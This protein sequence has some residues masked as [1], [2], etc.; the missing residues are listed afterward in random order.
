MQDVFFDDKN[1]IIA[2][3]NGRVYDL[4][5]NAVI[6]NEYVTGWAKRGPSGVI[7]TNKP[8]A[9][10][11]V[12]LLLDDLKNKLAEKLSKNQEYRIH[13]WLKSKNL[14]FV[15]FNQWKILDAHETELGESKE[16][17]REKVTSIAEML[18][19]IKNNN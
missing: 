15:P 17:P 5:N 14:Q 18:K 16:K 10:E 4:T 9:I 12:N 13:S 19:I 3:K 11:T 2:N 7:G 8:D 6:E 1:G